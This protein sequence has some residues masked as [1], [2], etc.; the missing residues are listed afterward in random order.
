MKL[1]LKLIRNKNKG[2]YFLT[3]SVHIFKQHD[4]TCYFRCTRDVCITQK[5]FDAG[6]RRL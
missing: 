6:T 4:K 2:H 5:Y 1:L 3:S